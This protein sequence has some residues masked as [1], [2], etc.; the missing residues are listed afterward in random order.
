M[1]LSTDE[2]WIKFF[3]NL[4]HYIDSQVTNSG[5]HSF[6]V[7]RYAIATAK[8]FAMREDEIRI[9]YWASL[10][11]DIGKIGVP[12]EILIKNGP[13]DQKEWQYMRLHPTLGAN[14]IRSVKTMSVISPIILFHQ[15]KF[16]GS[17]YP[18]GLKGE[19]IPLGS[20]I[21]AVV[22]AYDAMTNERV[23][24]KAY[25]KPE[26]INELVVSKG[27]QFDPSV[28][29]HFLDILTAN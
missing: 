26:A 11:H 28:V 13:L 9:T 25:S 21:L 29:D 6:Q 5:N 7:A 22:D 1:N 24:R 8:K 15:E 4:S 12:E 27:K 16:D 2:N 17:G 18:Y 23:Y 19:E 3:L 10:L 14:I 20:R